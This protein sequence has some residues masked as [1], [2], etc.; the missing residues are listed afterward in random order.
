M[1]GG[2]ISVLNSDFNVGDNGKGTM[3]LNGGTV[4]VKNVKIGSNNQSN[5][6]G[7]LDMR[8][9]T[10]N[11]SSNNTYVADSY[12]LIVGRYKPGTFTLGGGVLSM[13][14]AA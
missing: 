6:S 14:T 9:G 5:C 3:T 4:N 10:L 2:T 7:N 12:A 1:N 8:G 11:V 13:R